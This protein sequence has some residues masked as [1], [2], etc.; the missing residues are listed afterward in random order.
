MMLRVLAES[1]Q[2][3][4]WVIFFF[5]LQWFFFSFSFFLEMFYIS[6][7]IIKIK[8]SFLFLLFLLR[9]VPEAGKKNLI[10]FRCSERKTL[11]E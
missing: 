7:I 4:Y 9:L 6:H 8:L 3:L 2:L 10:I 5:L 11:Q 1:I